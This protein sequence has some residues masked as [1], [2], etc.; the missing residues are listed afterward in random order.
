MPSQLYSSANEE[1]VEDVIPLRGYVLDLKQQL[2]E[3][4]AAVEAYLRTADEGQR[5]RFIGAADAANA[6]LTLVRRHVGRHPEIAPLLRRATRRSAMSPAELCSGSP[7][8]TARA[9]GSGARGGHGLQRAQ[10][11]VDAMLD[12]TTP[13]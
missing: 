1:Y 7:A 2:L 3:Q 12:R 5:R 11:T 13:T 8:P 10:S 4:E 9:R 6:D